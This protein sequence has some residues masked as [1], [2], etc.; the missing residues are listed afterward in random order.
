MKLTQFQLAMLLIFGLAAVGGLITF[1][2]FQANQGSGELRVDLEMWGTLPQAPVN[3]YVGDVSYQTGGLTNIVYT[4]KSA[5]TF[6][7]DLIEAI[8]DGRGPDL[9][10]IPD[11]LII[12]LARRIALLPMEQ[13]TERYFKDTFAEAAE[14][15]WSP[16]GAYG[17]PVVI[18]PFLLF[19]NRDHLQSAGIASPP[20]RWSS[21]P[22]LAENLTIKDRS[23]DIERA[24]VA[25]GEYVNVTNAREIIAT[26]LLQSG[27]KIIQYSGNGLESTIKYNLDSAASAL[28]YFIQ[29]SNPT[30][31]LYTWNRSLPPSRDAFTTDRLTFYFGFG[32]EAKTIRDRNPNLNFD[33]AVIPQPQGAPLTTTLAKTYGI[34]ALRTSTRAASAV[35]MILSEFLKPETSYSLALE[36]GLAPARRDLLSI[37]PGDA[38]GGAMYR[39]AI[40]GRSWNDPDPEAS[41]GIFERMIESAISGAENVT[42][43]VQRADK[44]LDN[45]VP[46]LLF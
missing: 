31:P 42:S 18:D 13:V 28:S 33:V 25:M 22:G 12:S 32:S 40:M 3:R 26:F 11:S 27:S 4:E 36:L 2:T 15:F 46:G 6:E 5:E 21:L 20:T 39:S 16:W 30:Y 8:A 44:E 24:T 43:A 41:A 17:A 14:T 10:F 29:F 23:F 35:Q 34:A 1:A 9:V 7:R 38:F 19:W 45:L 37:P